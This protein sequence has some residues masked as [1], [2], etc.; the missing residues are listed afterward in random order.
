MLPG[1]FLA[2]VLTSISTQSGPA[3]S[4]RHSLKTSTTTSPPMA[5]EV[6]RIKGVARV[7]A[8]VKNDF[9]SSSRATSLTCQA[10]MMSPMKCWLLL[11]WS[12]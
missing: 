7:P 11:T 9:A 1:S 4:L 6:S 5:K 2:S 12:R 10:V 3:F 8:I